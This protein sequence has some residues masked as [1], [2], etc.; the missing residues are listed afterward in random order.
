MKSYKWAWEE[1]FKFF[2]EANP[3]SHWIPYRIRSIMIEI[4]EKGGIS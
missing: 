1:M 3:D 2:S 4:E